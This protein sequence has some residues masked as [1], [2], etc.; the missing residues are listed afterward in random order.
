MGLVYVIKTA[1]VLT[2]MFFQFRRR[3]CWISWYSWR[4]TR[5]SNSSPNSWVNAANQR[6]HLLLDTNVRL[7]RR[8]PFFCFRQKLQN[9]GRA[10]AF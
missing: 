7:L 3:N 8:R 6:P 1:L 9:V 10:S 4:Q 5:A 2:V